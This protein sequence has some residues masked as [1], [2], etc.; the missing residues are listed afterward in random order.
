MNNKS[1][2]EYKLYLDILPNDILQYMFINEYLSPKLNIMWNNIASLNKAILRIPK[3]LI[4]DNY[5]SG[6]EILMNYCVEKGYM[7]ILQWEIH[8]NVIPILLIQIG[9]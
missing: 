9:M 2:Y 5:N 1:E 3:N 8:N 7:K 6:E 4:A